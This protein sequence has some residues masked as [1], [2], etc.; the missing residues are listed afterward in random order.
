MRKIGSRPLVAVKI[1]LI[2]LV[3][4]PSE[5]S[6]LW[7]L[8][9]VRPLVPRLL[10]NG[11]VMSIPAEAVEKTCT[12][13]KSSE[14]VEV[15]VTCCD[16]SS[17]ESPSGGGSQAK[18]PASARAQGMRIFPSRDCMNVPPDRGGWPMG[19]PFG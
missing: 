13:P 15:V 17:N 19:R 7:Q 5:F 2:F 1:W 11:F 8:L 6:S 16:V 18:P 3:E 12:V 10:K 4:I 14:K 9:Q